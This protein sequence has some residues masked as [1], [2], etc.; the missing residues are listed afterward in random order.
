[1]IVRSASAPAWRV[2][3]PFNPRIRAGA[4]VMASIARSNGIFL[5]E[6][7]TP[8]VVSSPMIPLGQAA[9]SCSFSS[10]VWG[11]W[12]LAIASMVPSTTPSITAS[13]SSR[14][15]SGGFILYFD[16]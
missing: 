2:P 6:R 5:S 7:I 14:V 11:A 12:S 1:M 9:S 15:R 16:S 8:R 3:F 4:T 10:A 13:T